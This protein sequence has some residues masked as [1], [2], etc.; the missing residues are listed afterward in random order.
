MFAVFFFYMNCIDAD[1]ISVQNAKSCCNDLTIYADTGTNRFLKNSLVHG[2]NDFS[3]YWICSVL[4]IKQAFNPFGWNIVV[5][6]YVRVRSIQTCG[7]H[8]H[9]HDIGSMLDGISAVFENI[10]KVRGNKGTD[11]KYR[12]SSKPFIDALTV[13]DFF[14]PCEGGVAELFHTVGSVCIKIRKS[15]NPAVVQFHLMRWPGI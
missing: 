15:Q 11:L 8:T 5:E 2:W 14:S 7:I 13:W 3:V 10:I 9:C 4:Q 1:I 12:R 6:R